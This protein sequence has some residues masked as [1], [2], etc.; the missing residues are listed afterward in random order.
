MRLPLTSRLIVSVLLLGPLVTLGRAVATP[1][2]FSGNG[3]SPGVQW[4]V[5]V[6]MSVGALVLLVGMW[7]SRL[8]VESGRVT[9]VRSVRRPVTVTR[10]GAWQVV[11]EPHATE[12]ADPAQPPAPHI[13]IIGEGGR[14][15]VSHENSREAPVLLPCMLD[16]TLV[17]PEL[18]Q[19][20]TTRRLLDAYERSITGRR[21]ASPYA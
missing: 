16:W 14:A 8:V 12:P 21:P 4:T 11:L 6:L 7:R 17:R 19:D 10:D 13:A 9:R 3:S 5:T 15:I 18:V 20:T 1:T 2:M